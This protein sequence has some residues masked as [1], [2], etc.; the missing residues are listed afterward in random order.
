MATELLAPALE[1][2][3]L[4]RRGEVAARGSEDASR[5][6]SL[7]NGEV[8]QISVDSKWGETDLWQKVCLRGQWDHIS[9]ELNVCC[10]LR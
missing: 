1:K 6:Q 3:G 8:G 9:D 5:W 2:L 4:G 10:D 7:Q